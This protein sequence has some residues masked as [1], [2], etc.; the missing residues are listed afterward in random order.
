MD[1]YVYRCQC[2]NG[3][4]RNI[5]RW[6]PAQGRLALFT[7]KPLCCRRPAHIA[8]A[9]TTRRWWVLRAALRWPAETPATA[10]WATA[11]WATARKRL[12][13]SAW[14]IKCFYMCSY[15]YILYNVSWARMGFAYALCERACRMCGYA[16]CVEYFTMSRHVFLVPPAAPLKPTMEET[17]AL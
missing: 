16:D 17:N 5:Q 2:R 11:P 15:V 13:S 9:R 3:G 10:P 12:P 4:R 14:C 6:T 7:R 8:T 1:L